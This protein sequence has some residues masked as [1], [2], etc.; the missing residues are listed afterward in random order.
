M[1]CLSAA[2][3]AAQQWPT[4]AVCAA[5]WL[6]V[7]EVGEAHPGIFADLDSAGELGRQFRAVTPAEQLPQIPLEMPSMILLARG[8]VAGDAAS[9]DLFESYARAC[10]EVEPPEVPDGVPDADT[11]GAAVTGNAAPA[12]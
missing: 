1:A 2:P 5:L 4:P 6:G 10:E 11:D 7:E 9:M 12:S 3:V 8:Y